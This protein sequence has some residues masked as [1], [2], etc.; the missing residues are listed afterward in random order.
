MLVS[1]IFGNFFTKL[2]LYF[3]NSNTI[4]SSFWDLPDATA[5]MCHYSIE[6]VRAQD[7]L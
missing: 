4:L 5:A 1:S 6:R 7:R 2:N 3:Y